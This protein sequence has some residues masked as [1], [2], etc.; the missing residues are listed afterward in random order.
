[1]FKLITVRLLKFILP[2]TSILPT[3][4]NCF[5]DSEVKINK[6]KRKERNLKDTR[7]YVK[8]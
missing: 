3:N 8:V 1:M 6:R 2:V 5:W 4:P 7:K